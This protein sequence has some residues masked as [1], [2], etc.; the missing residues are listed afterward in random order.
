MKKWITLL[1]LIALFAVACG[2]AAET[3]LEAEPMAE[4]EK[5]TPE[6]EA[7]EEGALA[8][9]T[10]L[11]DLET[12][13][14]DGSLDI[15]SMPERKPAACPE[16]D[17]ALYQLSQDDNPMQVAEQLQISTKDD[18]IQVMLV[19]ADAETEIPVDFGVEAG[20]QVENEVQAFVPVDQLCDLANTDA[21]IGIRMA[22]QAMPN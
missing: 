6:T 11:P 14:V 5:E 18:K 10:P 12:A 22:L 20:T 9:V 1:T 16:L 7:V 2:G 21:I 15:E 3:V 13:E 17:S 19:L 8:V 4:L